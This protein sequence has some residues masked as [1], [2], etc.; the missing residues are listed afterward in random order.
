MVIHQLVSCDGGTVFEV[1]TEEHRDGT[2]GFDYVQYQFLDVR[3]SQRFGLPL[4]LFVFDHLHVRSLRKHRMPY[5][6]RIGTE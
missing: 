6:Q 2:D 4:E 3:S 1:C 5:T